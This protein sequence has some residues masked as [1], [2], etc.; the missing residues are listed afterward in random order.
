MSGL[1]QYSIP[2]VCS[3]PVAVFISYTDNLFLSF[4]YVSTFWAQYKELVV[5]IFAHGSIHKDN[6]GSGFFE[7]IQQQHLV[8]VTARQSIWRSH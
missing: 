2:R 1:I 5:W 6:F 7:F 8:H 4:S 3:L